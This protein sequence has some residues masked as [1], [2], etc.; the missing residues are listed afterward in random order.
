MGIYTC[1]VGR[2]PMRARVAIFFYVF[3]MITSPMFLLFSLVGKTLCSLVA[4][5]CISARL[6]GKGFSCLT[7]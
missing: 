4:N 1:M 3:D 5:T 2:W 6:H 7:K